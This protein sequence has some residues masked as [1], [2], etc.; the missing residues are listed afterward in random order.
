MTDFQEEFIHIR[1]TEFLVEDGEEE[2]LFNE[3]TYGAALSTYLEVE[4]NKHG[5]SGG[6]ILEDWGYWIGV[7]DENDDQK[8]VLEAGV[9]C[10]DDESKDVMEYVVVV[11]GHKLKKWNW[12]KFKFVSLVPQLVK[13]QAII[14]AILK[15]APKT[16]ILSISDDMPF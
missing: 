7:E 10:F 16:E 3:G 2:K 14:K 6:A 13:L 12:S 11:A 4:L 5:Y 1:T 15:S 9:Y 8:G